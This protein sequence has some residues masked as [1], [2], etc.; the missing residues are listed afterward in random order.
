[1]MWKGI[2]KSR[3][4]KVDRSVRKFEPRGI[5]RALESGN[6]RG[7]GRTSWLYGEKIRNEGKFVVLK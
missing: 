2:P 5:G 4:L 6:C 3:S 1:M 7:A